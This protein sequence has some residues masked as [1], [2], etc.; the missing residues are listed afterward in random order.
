MFVP[1]LPR[2]TTEAT[3]PGDSGSIAFATT[4]G[5]EQ[6]IWTMDGNGANRIPFT[7]GSSDDFSP[8]WNAAGTEIV[9]RANYNSGGGGLRRAT[10][11]TTNNDGIANTLD[12]YE[13]RWAPDGT[14]IA[15]AEDLGSNFD[16]AVINRNG[17]GKANLTNTSDVNEQHPVFSPDG[18]KIAFVKG[19]SDLT[20]D[21]WIM[22]ADGGGSAVQITNTPNDVE[23]D[24]DFSPNGQFLAFDFT[25]D[26]GNTYRVARVNVNGAGYQPLTNGPDDTHPS[27][28]AEGNSIAFA[29]A[30]FVGPAAVPQGPGSE[31]HIILVPSSGGAEADISPDGVFDFS[32]DWQAFPGPLPLTWG[33]VNCDGTVDTSDALFWLSDNAGIL[34]PNVECPD[35]GEILHTAIWGD[36]KWGNLDCSEGIDTNDVMLLLRDAAGLPPANLQDCPALGI[37]IALVPG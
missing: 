1:V 29:R 13:P 10:F 36:L 16:I 17:T 5:G 12:A 30:T 8:D 33:D 21:I 37:E 7:S 34:F 3:F 14:K 32:P 11:G 6:H 28:S 26:G 35:I 31:S 25:L 19:G 9:Y 4:F 23:T 27:W 18:S 22:N 24:L 15:F 2:H 20:G